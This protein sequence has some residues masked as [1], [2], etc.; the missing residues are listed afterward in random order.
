[1]F[2]AKDPAKVEVLNDINANVANF[3]SV[4]TDSYRS[5][6]L[7]ALIN[8]TCYHEAVYRVAKDIY[9]APPTGDSV[10]RAW[11]FFVLS[12]MSYAGKLGHGF[13]N[14]EYKNNAFYSAKDLL[15]YAVKR[16]E[17][18]QVFNRDALSVIKI[19]NKPE[20]LIYC[21]PPYY[22]SNCGHY[23]GYTEDAYCEL[24]DTLEASNTD[25]ILSS[26]PNAHLSKFV[27]RMNAKGVNLNYRE[28]RQTIAA[29]NSKDTGGIR[30][31]KTETLTWRF[32]EQSNLLF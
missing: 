22:N 8:Q 17:N 24:L 1:V 16:L 25:F 5:K 7:I 2:F 6:R 4:L 18:V 29:G 3:Y 11:A 31:F 23:G 9:Y 20:T 15:P 13:G 27:A 26:Y 14:D 19:F 28:I 30:N 32:K 10:K 21:D 12:R